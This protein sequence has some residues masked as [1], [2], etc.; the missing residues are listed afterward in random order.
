MKILLEVNDNKAEFVMELLKSIS[1]VKKAK[2]V[3][4]NEITNSAI[5]QSIE[6]YEKGTIKPTALS[7]AKLKNM[8]NA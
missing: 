3:S 6:A 8:L 1:F 7:L 5:L 2:A 4:K